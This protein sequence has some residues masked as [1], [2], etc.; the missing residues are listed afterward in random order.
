MLGYFLAGVRIF[1]ENHAGL[2]ISK[3][4]TKVALPIYMAYN[5]M[6]I[7]PSREA[8]LE[9]IQL[10]PFPF[11]LIGFGMLIGL[12]SAKLFRIQSGRQGVFINACSLGNTVFLGI[13]IADF[14][15]GAE[16][17][18]F[19]MTYYMANTVMFWT[20]GTYVLRKDHDTK[21]HF[22]D[23]ENLKQIFSPCILGFLS[24]VILVLLRI[25]IPAF[26]EIS[27]DKI[28][29]TSSALG[30]IFIGSIIREINWK[31]SGA[32]RDILILIPYKFFVMPLL[33]L[34]ILYYLP[35]PIIAKQAFY[36]LSLMPGM[37]QLGLMSR[38]YGSD[39][40]FAAT[41]IALST[42]LCIFMLPAQVW[43]M[44]MVLV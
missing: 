7:Y 35:L 3:Y 38:E 2:L 10:T 17:Q 4:L 32:L 30:M 44:S 9:T 29:D 21:I 22:F 36:I 1:Q 27:M 6:S 42:V 24:G 26:L 25:P 28:S 11:L 8:L 19:N 40:V 16:S 31:T 37:T 13:P 33:M 34:A 14:V 15:L 12:I 18:G 39:A 20:F 23:I 5:T 41:W 43:I